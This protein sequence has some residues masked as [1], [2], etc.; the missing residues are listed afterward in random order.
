MRSKHLLGMMSAFMGMVPSSASPLE[1]RYEIPDIG[2]VEKNL[3]EPKPFESKAKQ[4]KRNGSRK[5]RSKR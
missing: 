4:K 2:L 1:G 5:P 3:Y